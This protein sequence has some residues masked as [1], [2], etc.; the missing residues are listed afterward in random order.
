M[1]DS[2]RRKPGLS[3]NKIQARD[4]LIGKAIGR[5][6]ASQYDLAEPLSERLATLLRRFEETDAI[7]AVKTPLVQCGSARTTSSASQARA[8]AKPELA[9]T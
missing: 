6:L 9:C 2:M 7:G 5:M 4:S 1:E 8:G 3:R